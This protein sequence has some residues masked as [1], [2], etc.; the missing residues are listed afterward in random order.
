MTPIFWRALRWSGGV[1][2]AALIGLSLQS[3]SASLAAPEARPAQQGVNASGIITNG[4]GICFPDAVLT[5]CNGA[6]L[7]QLK[8]PGG[9]AFF[10]PYLGQWVDL[11]GAETACAGGGSFLNVVSMRAAPNPCPGSGQ[12]QPTATPLPGATAIPGG[13]PVPGT[14]GNLALG[15]AIKASSSQAGFPPE[16]A[17]DGNMATWWASNPGRDPRY[18]ARNP[19]WIYIDLGSPQQIQSVKIH[20]NTQ[21]HARTY[22]LYVWRD[23]CRGWCF[24]GGTNV[25]DGGVD[26]WTA[27]RKFETQYIML[28]L[29]NPYL[30]GQDYE[31]TEWEIF[32]TAPGAAATN[33]ARGKVATALSADPAYPAANATDGDL[34]TEWRSIGGAPTWFYVDLG[35]DTT[36]NR[37]LLH[38]SAGLHATQYTLYSWNGRAWSP[39]HTQRAGAGGDETV[40]VWTLRTRYVLLYANAAAGASVGLRELEV[41]DMSTTGGGGAPG[42]PTPPAPPPP[43]IPLLLE[44]RADLTLGTQSVFRPLVRPAGAPAT[45]LLGSMDRDVAAQSGPAPALPQ[46]V[47]GGSRD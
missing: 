20:W 9:A 42:L 7:R 38:W 28:N 13:T 11:N 40:N 30:M 33:S 18:P 39:F 37:L 19:Q 32:G 46:P 2:A 3:P 31:I 26:D 34:A 14:P 21:R 22:E 27:A 16:N 8:G 35:A 12:Q 41:F 15:R 45:R 5:D 10:S 1:A 24:G 25:G 17:I 44:G 23:E 29:L 36:L 6:V 47:G 4:Q 43:P